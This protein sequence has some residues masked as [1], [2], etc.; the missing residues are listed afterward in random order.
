MS[1]NIR[2]DNKVAVVTGVPPAS[3]SLRPAVRPVGV[4]W[5]SAAPI[6]RSWRAL[7]ELKVQGIPA[8]GETCVVSD[9]ESL[10]GLARHAV[11]ALGG[12]DI[13]VSNAGVYPQYSIIDTP[14]NVWDKTVDTNMKS[15]YLGAR[16]AY[17]AMKDKGGVMLLASS[18]AAVF[19]SVGSGVYAATKAA[20]KSMVNTLAAE[21]APYGIRV[22]GY[23]PGVIDTDMTH[24]LTVSNGEAMKSAIAMQTFGEPMDVAWALAF[25]ASDYAR[26]I[27]GTT[28]EISGG[29]MGVQNPAKAWKDK[30]TRA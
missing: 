15:V 16:I 12:L 24:A 3:A 18:F 19:P 4:R 25:L 10:K 22:N 23:I 30:E 2:F 28:L 9:D 6:P 27:T 7:E 14:E 20:V 13:C 17:E 21:L 26:Y 5:P 8:V 29:K 11:E 1:M